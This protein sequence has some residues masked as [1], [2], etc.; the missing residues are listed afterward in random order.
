MIPNDFY[1]SKSFHTILRAVILV[2][3]T[4]AIFLLS[5][6]LLPP[7]G[8]GAAPADAPRETPGEIGGL[9]DTRSSSRLFR[10]SLAKVRS[11]KEEF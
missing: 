7:K 5:I 9:V 11:V 6:V 4:A 3:M 1:A 2:T 10:Q 8:G